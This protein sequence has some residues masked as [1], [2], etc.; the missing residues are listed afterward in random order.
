MRPHLRF[1]GFT[2]EEMAEIAFEAEDQGVDV[3]ELVRIAVKENL[4]RWGRE[5]RLRASAMYRTEHLRVQAVAREEE[6]RRPVRSSSL[7]PDGDG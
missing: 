7:V 3:A 5:R 1:L 2:S 4:S 6:A